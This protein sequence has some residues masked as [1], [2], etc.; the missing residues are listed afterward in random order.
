MLT[1]R[2]LP[3]PGKGSADLELSGVVYGVLVND[4][5]LLTSLGPAARE[6]PYKAPPTAP[7]MYIKPGNTQVE[8]GATV[9]VDHDV[10]GFLVGAAL[11]LVIGRTACRVAPADAPDHLA[12]YLLLID[13]TVPHASWY[14]PSVR[15]KARD[16]S[17]VFGNRLAA[18]GSLDPDALTLEVALD[19]QVV[20][21]VSTAGRIR[22][23]AALLADVTEFMTLRRGDILLTGLAADAVVAT[24]GQRVTVA[25]AGAAAGQAGGPRLAQERRGHGVDREEGG[26]GL[27]RVEATLVAASPD[28]EGADAGVR[29]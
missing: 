17:C 1:N 26:S 27:G 8:T 12:G 21:Q 28:P 6:A 22:S 9:V 18:V 15:F 14:R 23:A 13:L 10:P 25:V 7:V 29:R 2:R 4:P 19:G 3:D 11:G 24:A 5:A 20:Q 16:R